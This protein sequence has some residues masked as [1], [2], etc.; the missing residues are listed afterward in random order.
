MNPTYS[1]AILLLICLSVFT[2]CKQE[3][4][5]DVLSPDEIASVLAESMLNTVS[6]DKPAET[7]SVYTL[8]TVLNK[9]DI[10]IQKFDRSIAFYRGQN[11]VWLKILEETASILDAEKTKQAEADS[12]QDK[13]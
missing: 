1:A 10:S 4:P 9:R 3:T 2:S 6:S 12:S 8:K 13:K 5:V 11:S 7:D